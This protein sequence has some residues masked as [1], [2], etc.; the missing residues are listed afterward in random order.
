MGGWSQHPP[1]HSPP[2]GAAFEAPGAHF[3]VELFPGWLPACVFL[4]LE[5][6]PVPE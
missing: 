1:K 3:R 6:L 5:N 4:S 2:Y